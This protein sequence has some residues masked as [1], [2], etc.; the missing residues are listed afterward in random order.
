MVFE[1]PLTTSSSSSSSDTPS[2][3][4]SESDFNNDDTDSDEPQYEAYSQPLHQAVAQLYQPQLHEPQLQQHNEMTHPHQPN[5]YDTES[6]DETN[7]SIQK[8]AATRHT[9]PRLQYFPRDPHFDAP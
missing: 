3:S 8:S 5:E 9:R 6:D 7:F 1:E 2:P 4:S